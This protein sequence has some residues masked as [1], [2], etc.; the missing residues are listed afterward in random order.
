MVNRIPT[1]TA[2]PLQ[3]FSRQESLGILAV[4]AMSTA[5]TC[6]SY[7]HKISETKQATL[8]EDC[9]TIAQAMNSYRRDKGHAPVSLDDLVQSGY[10]AALPEGFKKE[11]CTW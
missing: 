9:K 8:R 5:I 3:G 1:R 4:I 7:A 2:F 10:L 11:D 6:A